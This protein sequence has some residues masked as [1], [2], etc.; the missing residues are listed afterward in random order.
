MTGTVS[1][2]SGYQ[3]FGQVLEGRVALIVGVGPGLGQALARGFVAAGADVV[4]VSRRLEVPTQLCD[5]LEGSGHRAMALAADVTNEDQIQQLF[6]RAHGSMGRLDT[7][8]YNAFSPP[9]R[10]PVTQ[11]SAAHWEESFASNVI[12]AARCARVAAPLLT[13]ESGSLVMINSQAAR[14][15]QARRGPYAASKAALLSLARTL[16]AELG[17]QGIRVNSVVPGHIWGPSLEEHFAERARR[18]GTTPEEVHRSVTRDMA[19]GR[20]V[21]PEEVANAAVFLASALASGIT[22]Q[23][24][25]VNAGNW[26]E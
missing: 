12:G 21:T 19:L 20:I 5:D 6:A 4:L 16:A 17:P 15:S 8:V 24:L 25:D 18:L 22:G 11:T 9:R 2:A 7:V 10:T 13:P 26:F 23:S 3:T 1:G 14:R